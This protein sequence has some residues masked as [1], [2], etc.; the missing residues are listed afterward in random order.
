MYGRDRSVSHT[1][2]LLRKYSTKDSERATHVAL[3]GGM[4]RVEDWTLFWE[5]I[6]KDIQEGK[7]FPICEIRTEYF[8]MFFDLDFKIPETVEKPIDFCETIV[9]TI[10]KQ[11]PKFFKDGFQDNM[12]ETF[13]LTCNPKKCDTNK[14]KHGFHIHWPNL[15]VDQ[16]SAFLIRM[17]AISACRSLIEHG[18]IFSFIDLDEAFDVAPFKNSR[19]S[20][21]ILHA[22]KP[23]ICTECNNITKHKKTCFMCLKS[24]FLTPDQNVY[25]LHCIINDQERSHK[26]ELEMKNINRLLRSLC[27]RTNC[28]EVTKGFEK[29]MGCPEPDIFLHKPKKEPTLVNVA[30]NEEKLLPK[31]NKTE[32]VNDAEKLKTLG[33]IISKFGTNMIDNPYEN[34]SVRK[35]VFGPIVS[36]DP[37]DKNKFQYT[38]NLQDEGSNYCPFKKTNHRGNHIFMK[39][40]QGY[41][42]NAFAQLKCYDSSCQGL[43]FGMKHLT[44]EQTKGLFMGNCENDRKSIMKLSNPTNDIM[45]GENFF[46]MMKNSKKQKM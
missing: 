40:C 38:V 28:K 1:Y 12:L 39:V 20:L 3:D 6:A 21:R 24:G 36:K 27:I 16:Y 7:L 9:K 43:S 31:G 14:I 13:I 34:T 17:S 45:D 4:W 18:N 5:K 25:K 35:A 42:G 26:L 10:N 15:I 19:G 32:A 22:P 30:G 37:K 46:Q 2:S 41:S 8:P 44:D 29:Y 23:K 33:S 11:I